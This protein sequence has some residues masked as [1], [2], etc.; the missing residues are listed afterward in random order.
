MGIYDRDY[1]RKDGPSFLGSFTQQGKACKW[2]I[3]INVL[4]FVAQQFSPTVTNWLDLRAG[5]R[6]APITDAELLR[7]FGED[8][9]GLNDAQK[10]EVLAELR[11]EW[12]QQ[13]GDADRGPGVLQGQVWRLLTYA[14]L[15]AGIWHILFNMLF[16][17]WFGHEIEE[18]VRHPRIRPLL[19]GFRPPGRRGV[20]P[21]GPGAGARHAPCLGAS[22]AVTAVMVLYAFHFP[23]RI[24]RLWFFL[25]IP[26]WLFVCSK[27]HRTL[28]MFA[29]GNAHLDGCHR[30]PGRRRVRVRLL[31]AQL[32]AGGPAWRRCL[33][34]VCRS[35]G[36]GYGFMM[37]RPRPAVRVPPP[38]PRPASPPPPRRTSTSRPRWTQS[39][40]RWP[41]PAGRASVKARRPCWCGPAK[42]TSA[43]NV[44]EIVGGTSPSVAANLAAGIGADPRDCHFGSVRRA[45]VAK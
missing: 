19:P 22:G 40:K 37:R 7:Q 33:V 43:G 23:G 29:H 10:K 39:W 20:L 41:A 5:V 9:R 26:I 35:A 18:H 30:A 3:G 11:E 13:G 2:L 24:I 27:W 25:P 36:P 28:F 32:A 45:S 14:F 38:P 44:C 4:L 31:Q 21:S 12:R 1:Y 42:C 16:L 17:W 6:A 15:H 34:C 8:V